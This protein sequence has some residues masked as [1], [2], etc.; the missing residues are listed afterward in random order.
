[1]KIYN[2]Y[3]ELGEYPALMKIAQV[4][5]LFKK[6]DNYLP[7][8]YRPISLLACFNKIFEKLICKKLFS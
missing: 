6:G 2:K 1:M 8:N 4:I 7:N 5:A 3:L